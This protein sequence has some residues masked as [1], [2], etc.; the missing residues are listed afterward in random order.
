VD[1]KTLRGV[2]VSTICRDAAT[3]RKEHDDT[4]LHVDQNTAFEVLFL[5]RREY[6]WFFSNNLEDLQ[7]Y[8]NSSASPRK[9]Q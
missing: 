2:Q 6:R 7:G 4:F 1:I 9:S 8:K 5:K 3:G